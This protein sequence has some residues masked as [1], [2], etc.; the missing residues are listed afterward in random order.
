VVTAHAWQDW[1]RCAPML[2]L[3]CTGWNTTYCDFV[4]WTASGEPHIERILLNQV[5]I[6]DKLKQAEKLFWLAIIPELLGKWF[7]RDHTK[8]P[9]VVVT[10]MMI[11]IKTMM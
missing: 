10:T 11:Q 8:L 7:M 3:C 9:T 2:V 1:E 4:V 5:F 6:E